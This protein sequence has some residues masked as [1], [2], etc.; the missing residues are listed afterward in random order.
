MNTIKE[1][2]VILI[3]EDD[4]TRA[5]L[6]SMLRD[7]GFI[8]I[9]EAGNGVRAL[10][11]ISSTSVDLVFLDINLPDGDGIELINSI[12]TKR[13]HCEILIIS[14]EVTQERVQQIIKCPA[15]GLILKP[16]TASVIE[17]KISKLLPSL[18][19]AK[20]AHS[21]PQMI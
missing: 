17:K 19:S 10:R 16:F 21:M 15:K 9:L 12:K 7:L 18:L 2:T 5:Y 4:S 14:S 3:E 6:R 1:V 11:A 13:P 8:N 20:P